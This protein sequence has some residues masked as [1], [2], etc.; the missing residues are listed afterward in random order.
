LCLRIGIC[1]E[2]PSL[3]CCQNTPRKKRYTLTQP[4][5]LRFWVYLSSLQTTRRPQHHPERRE[6]HAYSR[7]WKVNSRPNHLVQ[8]TAQ[9]ATA[10]HNRTLFPCE[11]FQHLW[12]GPEY[13]HQL[14]SP[15][16]FLMEEVSW[17]HALW[18]AWGFGWRRWERRACIERPE[19]V[20]TIFIDR[21]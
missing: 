1:S 3:H 19:L 20:I 12:T 14:K 10:P 16:G 18:L 8:P 15:D 13:Q 7:A 5:L 11:M 6:Y 9:N 21:A 17:T 4:H 2:T